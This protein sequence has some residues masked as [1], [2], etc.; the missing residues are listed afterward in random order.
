MAKAY[1]HITAVSDVPSILK[2][3]LRGGT[4]PRNRGV[5]L[6]A[7]SVF[8]ADTDKEN[9][10]GGIA[11]HQV[12]CG[13]DIEEYAVIR[14]D[15]KG[16]TGTIKE[17][18]CAEILSAFQYIIEQDVIEPKQLDH[19]RNR[20]LNYP[21]KMLFQIQ[22]GLMKRRLTAEEWILFRLYGGELV[23]IQEAYESQGAKPPG[24]LKPRKKK[25][26]A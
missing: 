15:A 24:T 14:I 20:Q 7:P 10:L 16:V 12:W 5:S 1:W 6:T 25:R 8:V 26:K 22:D 4:K 2:H 9:I 3:G 13:E 23:H 11:I 17:D 18:N 21:G 19:V